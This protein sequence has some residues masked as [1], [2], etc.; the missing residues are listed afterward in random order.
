MSSKFPPPPPLSYHLWVLFLPCQ[1]FKY[2]TQKL[3]LY[4]KIVSLVSRPYFPQHVFPITCSRNSKPHLGSIL[5]LRKSE[6]NNHQ[7]QRSCHLAEWTLPFAK[8]IQTLLCFHARDHVSPNYPLHGSICSCVLC[9]FFLQ[10]TWCCLYMLS[11]MMW[12]RLQCH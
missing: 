4:L 7:R 9:S 1:L 5:L 3:A 10:W 6:A 8:S 2:D 11:H 12:A